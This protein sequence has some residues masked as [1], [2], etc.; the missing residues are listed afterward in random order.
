MSE[1][2]L[3]TAREAATLRRKLLAWYRAGNR[4]LPWR[5]SRDV[6]R[7]WISEAMLQ[8]TRVETVLGYWAR[9]VETLPTL[10]DLAAASEEEVL[11]LWS[12]L[13]YYS[14]ARR[15]REAAI[16]ICERH[17]GEFPRT[18]AEARAL[19]GVGPY[20]AGA[21][22][23]IAYG[24]PEPLVD[25]NVARVF[26]RLRGLEL[27]PSA[28]RAQRELWAL[29]EELVPKRDGAGDWNQALMEL[30][31]TVCTPTSPRCTGCPVARECSAHA[32]GRE[33][34][35]PLAKPK[36]APLE[37]SLEIACAV[38]GAE[39]LLAQRPGGGRM[40]GLWEPPTRELPNA[41]AQRSELYP[42]QFER[43]DSLVLGASLGLLR[44]SITRHRIQAE[45]RQ[46]EVTGA[47]P[48]SWRWVRRDELAGIGLTGMAK[49]V[50]GL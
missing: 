23:S 50:L 4:P 36:V 34:E 43:P 30:G 46:A 18:R 10:A 41:A 27:E 38:R 12:G 17:E 19:P 3:V 22:L 48:Q 14:R 29:A 20:T 6:Y 13:G 1:T 40:A 45:V 42:A 16:A 11:A 35:L 2:G 15:L 37:V 26:C 31:A 25:G 33:E 47:L 49:K 24:L 28:P 7:I 8:Q 44:H 32:Q 5:Q 9:F 39:V 21:V